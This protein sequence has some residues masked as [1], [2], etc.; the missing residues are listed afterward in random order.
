MEELIGLGLL[1]NKQHIIFFDGVC[2]LCNSSVDFILKADTKKT[3]LFASLQEEIA[4]KYLN[5]EMIKELRSIVYYRQ[6]E[7]YRESSAVLLIA[8]ELYPYFSFF[9]KA[10]LWCP[11]PLRD[12]F[13]GLVAKNR[14]KLF[15]KSDTCRLPSIDEKER[16]LP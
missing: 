10:L 4:K 2:N 13:Y 14:Y 15:G 6:G 3:F 1:E 5:S 8:S 9:F 16:F 12:F 11:S 7:I